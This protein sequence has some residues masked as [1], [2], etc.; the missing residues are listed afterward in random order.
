M[1]LSIERKMSFGLSFKIWQSIVVVIVFTINYE[2]NTEAKEKE[3]KYARRIFYVEH[4]DRKTTSAKHFRTYLHISDQ[5]RKQDQTH[6]SN[7]DSK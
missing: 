1:N 5:M 6:Y 2:Q 4:S 7:E 3:F